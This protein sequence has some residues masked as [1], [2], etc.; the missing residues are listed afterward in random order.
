[1][2]TKVGRSIDDIDAKVRQLNQNIKDGTKKTK[3]LDRTLKLDPRN[4]SVAAQQM[5]NL[6]NKE[7]T[8]NRHQY[9]DAN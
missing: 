6:T 4:T 1:M 7:E 8:T 2:A 5:R 3:E 9:T